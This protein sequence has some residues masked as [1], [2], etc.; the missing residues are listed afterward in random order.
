[1]LPGETDTDPSPSAIERGWIS[2]QNGPMVAESAT[3]RDI[4]HSS[5]PNGITLQGVALVEPQSRGK[6]QAKVEDNGACN[7][8]LPD[9]PTSNKM[10]F[11]NFSGG[12]FRREV[13]RMSRS[14]RGQVHS[15]QASQAKC[16]CIYSI[17]NGQT[18]IRT[19][20]RSSRQCPKYL[21]G[22]GIVWE[23]PRLSSSLPVWTVTGR[24]QRMQKP[25]ATLVT[26]VQ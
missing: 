6:L 25:R 2:R 17:D 8:M 18:N 4:Y 11:E 1:M 19:S 15:L 13:T 9:I 3:S 20:S 21:F 24:S 7:D 16:F 12:F 14:Q 10:G 26:Q 5:M 22:R 23:L